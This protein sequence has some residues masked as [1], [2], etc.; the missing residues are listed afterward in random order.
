MPF[1]APVLG[2]VGGALGIGA[3]AG[4]AGAA[5]GAAF[6]ASTFG[7]IA[8]K[9]LTSVAVSALA[10]AIAGKPEVKEAGIRTQTTMT[11]GVNPE[12][13]VLGTYATSG[14]MVAPPMSHGS[15][16]K[17][18]NAY[19]NYVTEVA[20]I[21]GHELAGLIVDGEH[22]DILSA[23]P[24]PDYGQR[25]GGRFE[26]RAWIRWH[27][28][29]QT[30][31]DAMLMGKYPAPHV[32]PWTA[33]MVGHGIGY[34]VLTFQYDREVFQGW[35]KVKYVLRGLPVYDPRRD[36]TA[37]GSGP[38][39]WNNPATWA[40]SDN[41]AVLIYNILRGVSIGQHVWG[42]SATADDLPYSVFATAMDVCDQLVDD[43]D[44]GQMRQYRGGFEVFAEDEPF[45]VIEELLPAC[46]GTLTEHGGV[47][48]LHCGAPG[49]PVMFVSDDDIIISEPQEFEPFPTPEST[50]NAITASYPDPDS[51]WETRE[52]DPIYNPEWEAE[53]GGR[54]LAADVAFNA[55][56]DPVQ[57]TRLM[58]S[59]IADHRRMRVHVITL[60]PEA[61]ALEPG[62]VIAWTSAANFYDAKLFEVKAAVRDPRVGLVRVSLREVDPDDY[63]PPAGIQRPPAPDLTPVRP[64]PQAVPGWAVTGIELR[65]V[66]G[67]ARRSAILASWD[68]EA[69]DDARGIRV[70]VRL[71]GSGEIHELPLTDVTAGEAIF[72]TPIPGEVYE[73]RGR[74]AADRRTTWTSWISAV[75]PSVLVGDKDLD[76]VIKSRIDQAFADAQQAAEDA[77]D[78]KAEAEG[79]RDYIDSSVDQ[80]KTDLAVDYAAAQQAVTDA[81]AAKNQAEDYASDANQ[82]RIAA[83]TARG[84]AEGYRDETAQS[85]TDAGASAAAAEAARGLA[86]TARNQAQDSAQAASDHRDE[87]FG[88]ADAASQSAG[89][90][91]QARIAAGT[92]EANAESARE[93]AV[94]ARQGADDAA[95]SALSSLNLLSTIGGAGDNLIPN[96]NFTDGARPY[97]QRPALW[98]EWSSNL[99]VVARGSVGH[100]PVTHAPKPFIV[101]IQGTGTGN[102]AL[103]VASSFPAEEGDQFQASFDY[104]T[105]LPTGFSGDVCIGIRARDVDGEYILQQIDRVNLTTNNWQTHVAPV[106]PAPA[107]TATIDLFLRA[108]GV[109][110]GQTAYMSDLT[111][112][113]IDP[114]ILS[115]R[116][117]LTQNYFT[118]AET[119]QAIASFDMTGNA[120]LDGLRASVTTQ[121]AAIADLEGNASAGY[122]IKA[123]AGNQ[124][125]L[126]DLVAADGSSG[127]VS[128]A[129]I[130]ATDI[131][132]EGSVSMRML[133]VT[134]FG[135]MIW[136]SELEND[137]GWSVPAGV[138]LNFSGPAG[139]IAVGQFQFSPDTTTRRVSWGNNLTD[140]YFRVEAGETYVYGA[141]YGVSNASGRYFTPSDNLNFFDE[142]GALVP[143]GPGGFHSP[144]TGFDFEEASRTATAPAGAYWARVQ[145][146]RGGTANEAHI[147]W[148]ER[149]FFRKLNSAA[150]LI[151][152]QSITTAEVLTGSLHANDIGVGRFSA[153]MINVDGLLT[154]EESA[155]LRYQKNG[156]NS[157][158]TDGIYFGHDGGRFGLAATRT[159]GG[160]RQSLKLSQDAGFELLNARHFVSGA[161]LPVVSKTTANLPATSLPVGSRISIEM[162]GG[163]GG[164]ASAGR[165]DITSTPGSA[166]G[167][168]VVRLYDG[169]TLM[170][171][172]TAPGGAGGVGNATVLDGEASDWDEGDRGNGGNGGGQWWSGG[173]GYLLGQGGRRGAYI[174]PNRVDTAGWADPRIQITIGAGGKRAEPSGLG[175]GFG[176]DGIGGAVTFSY[177]LAADFAADVIPL[178]PT[179]WG[180]LT[181]SG[182]VAA[183]PDL[184][185]GMWFLSRD[186]DLGLGRINIAPGGGRFVEAWQDSAISFISTYTPS[187]PNGWGGDR[188][189]FYVFYKMGGWS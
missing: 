48:K 52:A 132:L 50:Y 101:G 114:D 131:L 109:A 102:N 135:N 143:G 104:A 153:N 80:A 14:A 142:S 93:D 182:G 110:V 17:T 145:F 139:S 122:L 70:Q 183:F 72:D 92:S 18:P 124:V 39:R 42:G 170:H 120:S 67:D 65:D 173:K 152:P 69:A 2:F 34:A 13:F 127:S 161:T 116:A 22:V 177:D 165:G 126:L 23:N 118:R 51:L 33:D 171:T 154:I 150:T 8:V 85:V 46:S 31:A 9:L 96:G 24:H 138:F 100:F 188:S 74:I 61:G 148:V 71:F 5:A 181:Q 3:A 125:S 136:N 47:W 32:R 60:P 56:W 103:V 97:G 106:W 144:I 4:M 178:S 163:G 89:A 45:A 66:D 7:G 98:Q 149:P 25:L 83:E 169:T 129:R 87:A 174:S 117:D 128:V 162:V 16:G 86:V 44:G 58:H 179:A 91:N 164:G 57:V 186:G 30:A 41:L 95:A 113:K 81:L 175:H 88:F 82:Q 12:G 76:P 20:G 90:A 156:V 180:T 49:M 176:Q 108:N 189:I 185:G 160:K 53:D 155:G 64:A 77:A 38:Q 133:T 73:A 36:S 184:G 35:P 99:G 84:Q 159:S 130:A 63:D 27:D 19:L 94:V 55:V 147:G 43:G 26:G 166:G 123:Q 146:G 172:L 140:G 62:D 11:G 141:R 75:A 37:G 1:I 29:S 112:R 121:G 78:A 158:E 68:P 187:A 167:N 105:N 168:T 151:T 10:T 111:V 15:S 54:R 21:P 79:L 115:I 6:A 40:Y 134:D 59:L 28:G 119:N 157:D 137:D 107:G